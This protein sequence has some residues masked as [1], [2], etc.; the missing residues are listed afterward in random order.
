[1]GITTFDGSVGG[2]GGCPYA[3]GASGNVPTESLVY[4][5]HGMGIQTGIDL[6]KLLEAG[7]WIQGQLGHPLAS[8]GLR[9]YL[10]RK[11]R[12]AAARGEGP[13]RSAAS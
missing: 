11:A 5:F 12:A 10:G 2:L 8:S 13:A 4:M 3:P 9:A 6:D 1:M 7:E